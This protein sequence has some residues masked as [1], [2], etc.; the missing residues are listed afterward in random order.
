MA[1]VSSLKYPNKSHRKAV[2]LPTKSTD[3]AEFFGIMMGDGGINNQWQANITLNSV[4]DAAFCKYVCELVHGLF[5]IEPTLLE[6]KTRKAVRIVITSIEIV[7]FL[8]AN[9][10]KRG[11]K[12]K[13]ELV[14][15]EW[16]YV[17]EK[18][19]KACLR[20]LV[21]TDGCLY[22]YNHRVGR[23]IYKN[24]GLC[25]SS[26]SPSLLSQTAAIFEEFG[27][28]PH[29]SKNGRCIYLYSARAVIKYL[30][31][32]GTSNDRIS[33]VF[34]IWKRGRVVEGARLESV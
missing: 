10:L 24:I 5:G 26:Y 3:L 25:F 17:S 7:D 13:G 32:F 27:V 23:K 6:S 18:Y 15:P 31:I 33:S 4:A 21:D 16:I 11:N 14:L 22:V 19:R 28:M 12:L 29:I 1:S 20:G 34:E 8:V 9:G 30:E 2:T